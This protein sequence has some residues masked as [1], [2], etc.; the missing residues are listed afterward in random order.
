MESIFETT[1]KTRRKIRLTKKQ[2]IHIRQDHPEIEN[3]ELI[4]ETLEDPTKITRPYEGKKYYYYRYYKN[5]EDSDKYLLVI[6]NYLNGD[7]FVITA[8]YVAYIK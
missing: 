7:G 1:D 8:H 2:W 3:E 4:R 5:R 6:V